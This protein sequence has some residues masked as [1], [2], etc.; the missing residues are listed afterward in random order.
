MMKTPN[1]STSSEDEIPRRKALLDASIDVFAR[2]GYRKTSMSDVARAA[3]FSRQGVYF[4]YANKDELFK[5]TVHH[6]FVSRLDC[7]SKILDDEHLPIET[8]LIRALDE[9]EGRYVGT[10]GEEAVD[11]IGASIA[12]ASPILH[13]HNAAIERNIA[14]AISSEPAVLSAYRVVSVSPVLVARMLLAV[15]QSFKT[16]AADRRI[17]RKEMQSA[18]RVI[19]LPILGVRKR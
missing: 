7:V 15:A 10:L 2:F 17:F 13:E 6:S 9:W 4:Y 8:K 18:V 5:A 19:L 3:G 11:L 14:R 12:L 16:K 1:Q